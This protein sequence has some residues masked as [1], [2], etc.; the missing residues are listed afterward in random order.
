MKE[1]MKELYAEGLASHGGPAPC[2]GVRKD[3]V[4]ALV[5]GYVQAGY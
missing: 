1:E 3:V 4:E 5:G 2:G